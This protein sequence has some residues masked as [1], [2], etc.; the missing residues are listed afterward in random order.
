MVSPQ[1]LSSEIW[2]TKDAS[3]LQN[4]S[5]VPEVVGWGKERAVCFRGNDYFFM[6]IIY[7]LPIY[8]L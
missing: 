5:F 7:R 4:H 6:T 8:I 3:L 2:L 1:E